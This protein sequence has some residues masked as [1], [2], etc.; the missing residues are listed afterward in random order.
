VFFLFA[1]CIADT[2]EK[3]QQN[4]N[5]NTFKLEESVYMQEGIQFTKIAYIDNQPVL[6]L[7]EQKQGGLLQI[8]NE[9]LIVPRGSDGGF[10]T[11]LYSA[12]AKCP[13]LKRPVRAQTQFIIKH[14]AGEVSYESV[15]FLEKNRDTLSE[16]LLELVG[17][18]KLPLMSAL[19]PPAAAAGKVADRKA[20]LATQF[21]R[22]LDQLMQTLG[23][24]EPHYIRCIKPNNAK[25]PNQFVAKN[26][27]E[28]LQYSG[29]FE[30]VAIRRSG[31]PFRQTHNNFVERYQICLPDKQYPLTKAGCLQIV[32]DMKLN[33]A[34][35]QIG[36]TMVLYR[37]EENKVLE[38]HRSINMEKKLLTEKLQK[39]VAQG[40]NPK[41]PESY[42]QELS[43]SIRRCNELSLKNASIEAARKLLFDFIETRIDPQLK[44]NL[45]AAKR[46]RNAVRVSVMPR[47]AFV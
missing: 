39:L 13:Y 24:T 4:F 10:H 23:G 29:V 31:Y 25:A 7:I 21:Q 2:N 1:L 11:K 3:L 20:S 8:L 46:A 41:D 34:N 32:A 18:S 35:V 38:L 28:Q 22:Q 40:A 17:S 9:E 30:A 16:D 5:Q 14:Y 15:G 44:S 45:I 33:A 27:M 43:K 42:F 19:F 47:A 37:S 36:K 12:Q 26:V 6:D